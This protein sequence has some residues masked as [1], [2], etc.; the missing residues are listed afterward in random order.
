MLEFK[1]L[2][3]LEVAGDS[4]PIRLG[5]PRQRAT[6]AIL[7]LNANRVV[8]IYRLADDLYSGEPPVTAVTQVAR[9][10]S[11]L[12]RLLGADHGIETRSPG[13]LIR[14]APEQLDLST[15]ERRTEEAS[16]ALGNGEYQRAADL[17][18]D[19][20]SLWRGS[21]L[22]DLAD[23]QFTQPAID[24]LEEIRLAA[25]ERRFEAE[26][27]LGRHVELVG[28]L[29]KLVAEQPLRE[30]CRA[31]LM[32]ALY[33]SGRQADALGVFRHGRQALVE[34]FGIEPGRVLC[35]LERAILNQAPSLDLTAGRDRPGD[36][37]ARAVL[38][39]PADD[40]S[41]DRLLRVAEPLAAIPGR[42]LILARLVAREEELSPASADLT[43]RRAQLGVNVRTAAFTTSVPADDVVR[44]VSAHDVDLVLLEAPDD[45]SVNGIGEE[46]TTILDRSP[47]DVGLLV[48]G[49]T[50]EGSGDVI[51][52]VFGG[53][54]HDWAALELAAWLASATQARLRLVGT[55][56]DP[57]RGRRDASRLLADA[58]LAVQRLA[59]VDSEP[60]LIEPTGDALVEAVAGASLTVVGLSERWRVDGIGVTRQALVRDARPPTL[61]VHRGP[62]PGGLAP[63][64]SRTRFSW[65]I[66]AAPS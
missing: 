35:E 17:Q 66:A 14:L 25:F 65:S 46:L 12:R 27:G 59:G 57:R 1:I 61:L 15:F 45:L 20:L 2:G 21:P 42:E 13:Y 36:A 5:G 11:D 16:L 8:S 39:L 37:A 64:E 50:A 49:R 38:V 29:E 58:S 56:A 4:G 6:L 24:R 31:Q 30:S 53:S 28:Q 63:R 44:L 23:E 52:V 47:A 18:R 51:F 33:R 43:A 48:A 60:L 7:L 3:P 62:R 40:N 9:Q 10:V 19:A 32:L 54:E 22:A 41:L 26:L 55:S 34:E